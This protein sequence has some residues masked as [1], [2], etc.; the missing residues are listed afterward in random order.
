MMVV[1]GVEV[2]WS[3][4]RRDRDRGRRWRRQRQRRHWGRLDLT[5]VG[6]GF[7]QCW[8]GAVSCYSSFD[9]IC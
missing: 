2:D 1:V 4:S 5:Y 8:W 9:I 3:S 6:L 7:G